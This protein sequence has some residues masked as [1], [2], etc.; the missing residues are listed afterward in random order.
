MALPGGSGE[1]GVAGK[2][3]VEA[4]A[5]VGERPAWVAGKPPVSGER[6]AGMGVGGGV[7]VVWCVR[8]TSR[9]QTAFSRPY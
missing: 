6:P 9:S 2:P 3:A 1:P 7:N 8:A 4:A 5:A